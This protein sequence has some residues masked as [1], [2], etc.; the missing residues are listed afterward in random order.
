MLAITIPAYL[1]DPTNAEKNALSNLFF[2]F[3]T[4]RRRAYRMHHQ[5][6]PVSLIVKC[7]QQ[8][9]G[10]NARYA[11]DAY[12]SIKD[13]P[14]SGVTFGGKTNQQLRMKHKITKD[15]YQRRRNSIILSRG[16]KSRKGNNNIRLLQQGNGFKLRIS[17]G[18]RKWIYPSLFIPRKYLNR[19]HH[20][21]DGSRAYLVLIKR[22]P[23]KGG[24]DV[25]IVV[26]LPQRMRE[27]PRTMALDINSGHI[28][29]AVMDR[30]CNLVQVG[31]FDCYALLHSSSA[32]REHHLHQLVGRIVCIARHFNAKVVV[33]RLNTGSFRSWNHLANRS[34]KQMPQYR[35]RQILKY[36]LALQGIPVE[37]RSEAYT[38]KV[39]LKLAPLIGLDVHK[40][41]AILFALKVLDYSSFKA[42]RSSAYDEVHPRG[43][44]ADEANGRQSSRRSVG[45]GLTAL[46]KTAVWGTVMPPPGGGG[47][48]ATP[49]SWGLSGFA[50]GLKPNL[51]HKTLRIKIC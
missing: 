37:E 4:A 7:I 40:A 32:K 5:G 49:G 39:G 48:P 50:E 21:L 2:R 38:S 46:P 9:T 13:L 8:E 6:D 18:I 45:G 14:P 51:A 30:H 27:Q 33:G 11:K 34:I 36:K 20:L 41:S 23:N 31:R 10:L 28:D 24:F 26:T 1:P 44:R 17:L 35:F 43:V 19:Y 16:E 3:G 29:F 42:L 22:R 25:K 47:H 12:Y 15:E